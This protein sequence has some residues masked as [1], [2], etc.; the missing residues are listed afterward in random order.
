MSVLSVQKILVVGGNGLIGEQPNR[1]IR[2]QSLNIS[3]GS[4]MCRAALAKGMQVTS[5]RFTYF[6]LILLDGIFDIT[7]YLA[8]QDAHI[9]PQKVTAPRGHLKCRPS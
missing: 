3:V 6:S 9:P 7:H 1:S 4:A 2:F 5:V 8:L